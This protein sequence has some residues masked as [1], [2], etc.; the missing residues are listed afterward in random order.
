M[1]WNY[2]R[3]WQDKGVTLELTMNEGHTINRLN[4]LY[5]LYQKPYS[6]SANT[7]KFTD[8]RVFGIETH[9]YKAGKEIAEVFQN[10]LKGLSKNRGIKQSNFYIIKYTSMPAILTENGFYSNEDQ[11]REMLTK[12][13]QYEI[14]YQ[15]YKATKEIETKK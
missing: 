8:D 7:R 13:F 10:Q 3:R 4:K 11:C 6:L 15:H 1:I 2:I 5:A 14:A 9:Y 12:D